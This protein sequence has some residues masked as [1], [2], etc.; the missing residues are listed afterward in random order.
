[1]HGTLRLMRVCV[2]TITC[3]MCVCS[4]VK[5]QAAVLRVNFKQMSL[6]MDIK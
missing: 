5:R 1:M 6:D 3:G 4:S 2:F